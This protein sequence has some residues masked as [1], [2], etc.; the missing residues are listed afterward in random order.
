M[1][2]TTVHLLHAFLKQKTIQQ[3]LSSNKLILFISATPSYALVLKQ[4]F[5]T[6]N[7]QRITGANHNEYQINLQ[8][9]R[10]HEVD[11]LVLGIEQLIN[12]TKLDMILSIIPSNLGYVMIDHIEQMSLFNHDVKAEYFTLNKLYEKLAIATWFLFSFSMSTLDKQEIA[13]SFALV[14]DAYLEPSIN[15]IVYYPYDQAKMLQFLVNKAQQCNILIVAHDYIQAQ[16]S[17]FK[18]NKLI[19]TGVI[20]RKVDESSKVA[21]TTKWQEGI[22]TALVTTSDTLLPYPYPQVDCV[23]W[24][25]TPFS[26]TQVQSWHHRFDASQ[27]L[28]TGIAKEDSYAQATMHHFPYNQ[29]LTQIVDLVSQHPTGITLREME[30]ELNI[31]S[32]SFEKALKGLRALHALKKVQSKYVMDEPWSF[33]QELAHTIF[34]KKKQAHNELLETLQKNKATSEL[35]VSLDVDKVYR[36]TALP[37]K[38]KVLFPIGFYSKSLIPKSLLSEVGYVF[39]EPYD[40][41]RQRAVDVIELIDS[42]SIDKNQLS[43]MT[44]SKK[45]DEIYALGQHLAAL[46]NLQLDDVFDDFDSSTLKEHL[47]PFHKMSQVKKQVRLHN[48]HPLK[49]TTL[50]LADHADQ[51]WQMAVVAYELLECTS[52]KRVIVIFNQP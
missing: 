2:K 30:H 6:K 40:D 22:L 27:S 1:T 41:I 26:M 11:I 32:Y 44:L 50:V 9:L 3:A 33:N 39:E 34:I 16:M 31:E 4:L 35:V 37:L 29:T 8:A 5:P 47:N 48:N 25:E 17:A 45:N 24:I 10:Y 28:V 36:Y 15:S 49:K 20:H 12:P 18:L 19:P 51:S 7:I 23:V 43:I 38:A 21:T 14:D 42:N 52:T 13:H 46:L